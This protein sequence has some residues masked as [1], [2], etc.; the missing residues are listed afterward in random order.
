MK[1]IVIALALFG[2]LGA[3]AHAEET[4][5]EKAGATAHDA[6]RAVKKGVNRTKEA[7]CAEG[8]AKCLK[9]KAANRVEEGVDYTKDKAKEVKNKVD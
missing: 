7:F 1:K 6:K 3:A 2:F 5:G 9:D 8:D 4:M